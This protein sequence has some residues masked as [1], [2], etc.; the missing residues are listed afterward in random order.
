[1]GRPSKLTPQLEAKIMKALRVGGTRRA[2]YQYAGIDQS[3]FERWMNRN[4]AFAAQVLLAEAEAETGILQDFRR[5]MR[6]GDTAAIRFWLER[7]RADEWG[8]KMTDSGRELGD[9]LV[10]AFARLAG[11]GPSLPGDVNVIEGEFEEVSEP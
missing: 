8:P 1:M 9:A 3:T 10:A 11:I 7:R 2:A 4:A 5:A 6:N